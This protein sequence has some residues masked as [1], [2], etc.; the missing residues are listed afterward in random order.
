MT[1]CRGET[2]D[3]NTRWRSSQLA[4]DSTAR[5][6]LVSVCTAGGM[7]VTAILERA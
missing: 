5:R 2:S 7:G 4:G 3:E 1:H 6:A